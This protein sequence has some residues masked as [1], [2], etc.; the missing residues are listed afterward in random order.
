AF[1][2][3]I[4]LEIGQTTPSPLI[5]HGAWRSLFNVS[6][7][8]IKSR[9]LWSVY[10]IRKAKESMPMNEINTTVKFL[11]LGQYLA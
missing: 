2:G 1:F 7:Y 4:R 10:F 8:G 9:F 5:T 3:K 6:Q 11:L